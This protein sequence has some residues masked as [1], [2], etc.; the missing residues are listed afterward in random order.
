MTSVVQ[1]HGASRSEPL[2]FGFLSGGLLKSALGRCPL[3][4]DHLLMVFFQVP[5]LHDIELVLS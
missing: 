5:L 2:Q 1:Q 3:V 4:V